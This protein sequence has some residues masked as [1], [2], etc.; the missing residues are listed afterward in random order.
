MALNG[1]ELINNPFNTSYSPF[2]DLFESILTGGGMLF[3]LIPLI[4]LTLGIYIKTENP[5]MA[6]MFMVGGGS[7][8]SGGS[9]FTGSPAMSIVFIAFTALGLVGLFMSLLFQRR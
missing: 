2:T 1:S 3:W 8:L 5:V 9:I 6:M 4:G 7:L